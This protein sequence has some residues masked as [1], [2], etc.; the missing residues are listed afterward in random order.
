MRE[1]EGT[2]GEEEGR[3]EREDLFINILQIIE[4]SQVFGVDA[5]DSEKV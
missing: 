3:E 4:H 1:E 5:P 2:R